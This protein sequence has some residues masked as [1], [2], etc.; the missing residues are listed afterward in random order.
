MSSLTV[1]ASAG[2]YVAGTNLASVTWTQAGDTSTLD[3]ADFS[4]TADPANP[5]TGRC[6][7]IYNNTSTSDDVFC[8][9]DITTDGTTPVDTT[10]GLTYS[11][12][13]SGVGETVVNG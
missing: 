13:A 9:V 1:V 2:N 7:V 6:V 8:V 11:V 12:N 10:Q 3:C 4:F 5:I